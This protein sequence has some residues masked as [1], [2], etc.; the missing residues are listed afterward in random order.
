L[1]F[2]DFSAFLRDP[3]E[4]IFTGSGFVWYGGFVGGALAVSW[5]I[6]RNRLPWLITVDCIAPALALG[7][8]I[9]RI[10]CQLAGDG[11]WGI[12]SDL[13]W[14]MAYPNAI[15]GWPY[16]AGVRVHPT[17]LYECL[18]YAGVFGILWSLRK[19]PRP[20][21][22]LF[23]LYLL[24]APAARFGIEFVRTNPPVLAGLSQA[25]LFSLALVAI[26]AWRLWA[27]RPTAAPPGAGRK[28]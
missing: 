16:P 28:R 13:P 8:A 22:T 18:A 3:I 21:G 24:L 7:H 19:R 23:W 20:D 11:D 12:V 1:I 14:A 15:I 25:Q 26:G 27:A 4:M 2:E 17:P 6:R 5:V 10:G 9:G